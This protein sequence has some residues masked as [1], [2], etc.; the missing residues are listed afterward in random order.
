MGLRLCSAEPRPP[1][2]LALI[3]KPAGR[4][5]DTGEETESVKA[6]CVSRNP[7]ARGST[8]RT[9][10]EVAGVVEVTKIRK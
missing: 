4:A 9:Q 7:W 8:W 3:F 10:S 2:C 1:P 6:H 5:N